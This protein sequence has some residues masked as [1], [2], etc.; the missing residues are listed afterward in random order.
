MLPVN[1]AEEAPSPRPDRRFWHEDALDVANN[2]GH[3]CSTV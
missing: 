3:D 2:I 1:V